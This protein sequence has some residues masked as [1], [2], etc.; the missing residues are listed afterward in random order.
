M[1]QINPSWQAYSSEKDLV[2]AN[3]FW[4]DREALVIDRRETTHG[5]FH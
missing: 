5:S 2:E 1:G 3:S 4:V